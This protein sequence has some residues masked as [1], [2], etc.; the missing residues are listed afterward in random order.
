LLIRE[1]ERIP[2][3][4]HLAALPF[5]RGLDRD[6]MRQ[7]AIRR[8]WREY[9]AAL[10][11]AGVLGE[12][13]DAPPMLR[14]RLLGA[15]DGG[16]LYPGRVR[17]ALEEAGVTEATRRG[18]EEKRCALL[19][20]AGRDEPSAYY[21]ILVADGDWMGELIAALATRGEQRR[22]SATLA[23]FA[24]ERVPAIVQEGEGA[25]IYAG[26]D[27]VLSLL[28]LH[29]ALDTAMRVA[30]AFRDE[31]APWATSKRTPSLS[32]GLAV[33]HAWSPLEDGL[34][35]AREAE[36]KAK[37]R[38]EKNALAVAVHKRS[39]GPLPVCG[40]WNA[41]VLRLQ[42]I[43]AL[44]TEGELPG[45]MIEELAALERLTAGLGDEAKKKA[46]AVQ[47]AEA[48][49]ILGRKDITEKAVQ[50]ELRSWLEKGEVDGP[51]LGREL[52]VARVFARAA[53]EAMG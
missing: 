37:A 41:L 12:F 38:K 27:D 1:A 42:R 26:G 20:S 46:R 21:A 8:A 36:K 16:V 9:C 32:A 50:E 40:G 35:A 13:Q 3:T 47:R 34:F 31:L 45:T 18:V 25:L 7:E 17:E 6:E 10:E 28:P 14:S 15:I 48:Q 2:S 39:G 19:K 30:R 5:L 52:S 53:K 11:V 33:V 49:R 29:T 4:N 51:A 43:A 24:R 23:R 44:Q 22:F